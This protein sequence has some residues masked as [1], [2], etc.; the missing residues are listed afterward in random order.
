MAGQ[1]GWEKSHNRTGPVE[2]HGLIRAGWFRLS[3]WAWFTN[4]EAYFLGRLG[5]RF[6][7]EAAVDVVAADVD[8][9]RRTNPIC[10]ERVMEWCDCE[11]LEESA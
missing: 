8:R 2:L 9:D 7:A 11:F 6:A 3:H 4:E 1:A 10:G 5:R